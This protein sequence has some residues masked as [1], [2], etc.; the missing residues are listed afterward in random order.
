VEIIPRGFQESNGH[1]L[2]NSLK[3]SSAGIAFIWPAS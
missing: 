1:R 3:T 2:S